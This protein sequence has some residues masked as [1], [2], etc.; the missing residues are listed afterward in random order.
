MNE[1]AHHTRR[2]NRVHFGYGLTVRLLLLSTLPYE[3]AV[4]VGFKPESVC[5][6]RTSTALIAHHFRRTHS[7]ECGK[8]VQTTKRSA[9]LY[10]LSKIVRHSR[11]C[12]KPGSTTIPS[13]GFQ[14]LRLPASCEGQSVVILSK[15]ASIK[16]KTATSLIFSGTIR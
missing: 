4:T 14:R 16:I 12:V 1:L 5:L 2:P 11:E 3:N 7:R 6:G 8:P 15:S 13:F 9:V 10:D